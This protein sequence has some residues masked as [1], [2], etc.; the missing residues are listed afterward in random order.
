MVATLVGVS[1]A[2]PMGVPVGALVA[3]S[4]AVPVDHPPAPVSAVLDECTLK[5]APLDALA[6]VAPLAV[7]VQC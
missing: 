1:M 6:L 5:T 7:K 4:V 2:A 3:A